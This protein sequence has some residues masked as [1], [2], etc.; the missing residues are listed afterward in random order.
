MWAWAGGLRLRDANRPV[1]DRGVGGEPKFRASS[2]CLAYVACC[3]VCERRGSVL[4]ARSQPL[5]I[6]ACML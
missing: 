1:N 5:C 3:D 4:S 6:E 2:A